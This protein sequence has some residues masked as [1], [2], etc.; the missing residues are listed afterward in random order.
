MNRD[1]FVG[2]PASVA[3]GILWDVSPGLAAK[4]ADMEPPKLARPPRFDS[5][6]Y[7]R[8]GVTFASEYDLSGLR[9]WRDKKKQSSNP[10]FAEKDAKMVKALDY[11]IAWRAIEPTTPW[12]GERNREEVTAKPPSDRPEVYPRER[13]G[14]GST[15]SAPDDAPPAADYGFDDSD[16]DIPF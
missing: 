10:E 12:R 8:D 16:S 11:W 14:N 4:V 7:R 3:L 1:Q 9:F 5:I 13:R 2:L 6:I 15:T